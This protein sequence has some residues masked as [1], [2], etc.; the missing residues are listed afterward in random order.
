VDEFELADLARKG[1]RDL[2][3]LVEASRWCWQKSRAADDARYASIA[4]ALDAIIAAFDDQG[5][6]ID[7]V[8]KLEAALAEHLLNSLTAETGE[9]GANE[10]RQLR[11]AI[12]DI[13]RDS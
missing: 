5:I 4:R 1:L 7:T 10:A 6:H 11:E 9:A 8:K 13:L 2:P 3:S 12:E